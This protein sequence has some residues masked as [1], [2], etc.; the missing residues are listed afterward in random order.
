MWRRFR[1]GWL[2]ATVLVFALMWLLVRNLWL[3]AGF[4]GIALID[5]NTKKERKGLFIPFAT[6]WELNFLPE[7]SE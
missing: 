5:M 1:L 3:I 7:N 6:S 2:I 4:F